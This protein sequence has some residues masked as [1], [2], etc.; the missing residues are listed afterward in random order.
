MYIPYSRITIVLLL[1]CLIG[2]IHAHAELPNYIRKY[3]IQH[4]DARQTDFKSI[5]SGRSFARAID[6]EKREEIALIGVVKMKASAEF[7]ISKYRNIV[8]FESGPNIRQSGLF[9]SPPQISDVAT[10]T[11]EHDDLTKLSS[12][13]RNDCGFRLPQGSVLEVRPA[14]QWSSKNAHDQANALLRQK[15][16][17]LVSAYK[18]EGNHALP[19]YLDKGDPIRVN[20]GI[21]T[22][23]DNSKFLKDHFPSLISYV[24]NYPFEK[25]ASA[26]DL[27]Y[28]QKGEF[29]LQPVIRISHVTI[30]ELDNAA[31]F[32]Y[33]I[34]AK[35]LYANHYFRD[36]LEVRLLG[37][38]SC[39]GCGFYLIAINRSHADGMMGF[40]GL[41]V[42][43]TAIKKSVSALERWL[44]KTKTRIEKDFSKVE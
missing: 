9:S 20:D 11:W 2:S 12:C 10:L 6:T 35:M 39:A 18:N 3:L 29:G 42:R 24:R 5:D 21:N 26:E 40:K 1:A 44:I 27:F 23:L 37:P 13:K 28:W 7:Y 41:F 14:V 32:Q 15:V 8:E 25:N 34:A 43:P 19:V 36:A 17:N 33:A 22:L 16:L 30:F 38:D 4:A 31:D